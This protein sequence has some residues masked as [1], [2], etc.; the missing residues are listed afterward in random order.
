MTLELT[1]HADYHHLN[2]QTGAGLIYVKAF[3]KANALVGDFDVK[4][5]F[6]FVCGDLDCARARW[7]GILNGVGNEFVDQTPQG[8]GVVRRKQHRVGVTV[9]SVSPVVP[10]N[11]LQNSFKKSARSTKP[12]RKPRSWTWAMVATRETRFAWQKST[13]RSGRP[14]PIVGLRLVVREDG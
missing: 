1:H 2:A 13:R 6:Y 12:I 10:F 14:T 4:A 8:N 5:P 11:F 7:V 9:Q 3:R